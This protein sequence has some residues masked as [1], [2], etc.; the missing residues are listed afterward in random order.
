M[1]FK[2][3]LLYLPPLETSLKNM[4]LLVGIILRVS[5][6]FLFLSHSESFIN[7]LAFAEFAY[8]NGFNNP[9]SNIDN[10]NPYVLPYPS[11]FLYLISIP[12]VIS[13]LFNINLIHTGTIYFTALLIVLDLLVLKILTTW[14]GETNKQRL[15]YLYWL[16]PVLIYLTYV[17]ASLDIVVLGIFFVSLDYLFRNKLLISSF[18]LGVALSIKTVI[19]LTLPFVLLY[20]LSH[21]TRFKDILVYF[22]VI[23]ATFIIAN[24]QF[25]FTDS[26][27]NTI[28]ITSGQNRIFDTF[29]NFGG[30]NLY[31]IPALFILIIFR[32]ALIRNFNRD[33]FMMYLAFAFGIFL[34]FIKPDINW[35]FWLLP[36]LLYFYAKIG[37]RSSYLFHFFQL[38]FFAFIIF[39]SSSFTYN[40]IS[41]ETI[42]NIVYTFLQVILLCNII[43]VYNKGIQVFQDK[44]LVSVPFILGIG[45]NSGTGKTTLAESISKIFSKNFSL[46]L[47]GDDLHRWERGNKNWDN[48]THLNPK[49]NLIHEDISTLR[50]LRQSK[51]VKRKVYNHDTGSFDDNTLIQS[52]NLIIYEGLHPF[53]L[54]NQRNEYDLKIMVLPDE[55]LNTHWKVIRDTKNRKKSF[56]DVFSQIEV[57]KNDY[58]KFIKSQIPHA[59]I[60]LSPFAKGKIKNIG[61]KNEDIKIN[62]KLNINLPISIE[63]ILDKL[64]KFKKIKFEHNY[65]ENGSQMLNISGDILNSELVQL[66]ELNSKYLDDFGISN[67]EFPNGLYGLVVS[68]IISI[69]TKSSEI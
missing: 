15:L 6:S 1:I 3:F 11:L 8:S 39:N 26:Y 31:I 7:Y 32:G 21:K 22:F 4:P 36:H 30:N 29:I 58:E 61:D 64:E 57:R 5:L 56:K 47:K 17:L 63:D 34:I 55:Q 67:P 28:F 20:L 50:T 10:S 24:T 18:A 45:G 37:G 49:A 40:N 68:I 25:L 19:L 16:S 13:E 54:E 2:Q 48:Y 9:Y 43:W 42:M 44:K 66:N 23:L 65:L 27:L 46:I 41:Q 38:A 59:D 12:I 14:V 33:L 69:L 60:I 35:Y 52:K 62:Y 51:D 53:F